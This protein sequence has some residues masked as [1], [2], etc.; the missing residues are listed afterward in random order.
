VGLALWNQ[1]IWIGV[2]SLFLLSYCWRSFQQA[3]AL[4]RIE[5]LP[6]RPE[7]ACP[8]CRSSP[9]IGNFWR[10]KQ[11]S[12]GF[13]TFATGAVCPHCGVAHEVTTC[14]DCGE[15]RPLR[16]WDKSIRDA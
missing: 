5:K 16:S 8:D 7:F 6:R 3:R 15:A 13:D 14:P 1:S 12:Q 2:M 4:L 10:C 11:C 9:P